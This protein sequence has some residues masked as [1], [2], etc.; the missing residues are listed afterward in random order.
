M[1]NWNLPSRAFWALVL[2]ASL[3][4]AQ[5]QTPGDF[6]AAEADPARTAYNA[7]T[8]RLRPPLELTQTLPLPTLADPSSLIVVAPYILIGD[9]AGGQYTLYS[10]ESGTQVWTVPYP[11]T[12]AGLG[13]T[14]AASAD[15]V[16]LGGAATTVLQAVQL[17]TGTLLWQASGHGTSRGRNPV[18]LPGTAVFA[19]ERQITAADP[20]TGTVFWQFP[21]TAALPGVG[22]AEADLAVAGDRVFTLLGDG[23]VAALDLATGVPAWVQPLGGSA[24]ARLV[25][26]PDRL[27]VLDPPGG[28]LRCLSAA[29]GTLL[30]QRQLSAD[31]GPSRLALAY[32]RLYLFLQ[33][34]GRATA[35]ALD[36]RTG[37]ILWQAGD[38]TEALGAPLLPRIADHQIFYFHEG[39]QAVRVL[40]ATT[41]NLLWSIPAPDLRDLAVANGRLYLLLSDRLEVYSRIFR[42]F[43][44]QLAD[45]EGARTLIT[46]VNQAATTGLARVE[47]FDSDGQPLALETSGAAEPVTSLDIP[48]AAQGS[49]SVQTL[50]LAPGLRTGWVRVTADVPIRAAVAF[51]VVDATGIRHEAGIDDARPA[52]ALQVFASRR[53]LVPEAPVNTGVAIVNVGAETAQ[54]TLTL[55]RRLPTPAV[56]ETVF[57]LAPGAHT[58][59]FLDELFGAAAPEGC[60]GTLLI[61]ADQPV[62][63]AA[64]RTQN[65]YQLSSYPVAIAAR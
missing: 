52:G 50:G 47:F 2:F 18:A 49:R 48:L 61:S 19:D 36:V 11:G 37:D 20:A 5:A 65:G 9:G 60:E 53:S 51:Q 42:V 26:S 27:F 13:F 24:G 4:A 59:Q 35:L 57:L 6:A 44:P 43:V 34:D 23:S 63:A 62:A 14:P 46:V 3:H 7:Q 58:A 17:S 39:A 21:A 22:I 64:L 32:G 8:D 54:V 28:V 10:E 33:V 56:T 45:G 55:V 31:S 16:L 40:D 41:G 29:T 25:A 1:N 38:P 15:V 12:T 30:W